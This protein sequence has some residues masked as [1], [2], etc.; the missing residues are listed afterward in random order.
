M[1][2][3]S[4]SNLYRSYYPHRSREL[5]SPVCG[6]FQ[7]VRREIFKATADAFYK[8]I[9]LSVCLCVCSLLGYRLKILL[10]QLPE[11]AKQKQNFFWLILPFKTWRKPRFPMDVEGCI[12]YF[13][14]CLDI[15]EFLRFG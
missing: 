7:T 15:F 14:I 11:I 1:N 3:A 6:I 4:S 2:H 12:A 13:G 8:L 9:C 5:V 10:P